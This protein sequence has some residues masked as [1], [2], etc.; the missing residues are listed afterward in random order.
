MAPPHLAPSPDPID[1]GNSGS[2][3]SQ[4][5]RIYGFQLLAVLLGIALAF[6]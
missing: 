1:E 4:V 3:A 6:M 2:T 5:L